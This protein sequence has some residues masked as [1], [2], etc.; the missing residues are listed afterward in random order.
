MS[1]KERSREREGEMA[2][3]NVGWSGLKRRNEEREIDHS[4]RY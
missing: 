3:V 4:H 2:V 1:V